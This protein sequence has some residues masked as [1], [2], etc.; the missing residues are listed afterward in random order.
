[1]LCRDNK[2][3]NQIAE[4]SSS[5]INKDKAKEQIYN[6]LNSDGDASYQERVALLKKQVEALK[7]QKAE[8]EKKETPVDKELKEQQKREFFAAA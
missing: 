6:F 1:M 5:E 3:K 2:G 7:A 4:S 8:L